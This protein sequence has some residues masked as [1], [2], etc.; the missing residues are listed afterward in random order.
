MTVHGQ[1]AGLTRCGLDISRHAV[2]AAARRDPAGLY[3]VAGTHRMPVLPRRADVLLAQFSPVSA[4]D[5][6]RVVRPGGVVLVGGPGE[7]HLFS[8][9]ELLYDTPAQH[10]PTP[11]LSAE[12][13]FELIT[14]HRIRYKL[15][16]RG[17]GQV[18]NLL[19]MTPFYWSAGQ[20]TRGRLADLDTLDTEADVVVHAYRRTP[21]AAPGAERPAQ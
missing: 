2:R 10:E 17:P 11:T 4:E 6:R 15:M 5:F 7:D 20:E 14:T 19:T 13:G 16:L 12:P 1:E 3:A 8:L 9:K 18:A 21:D